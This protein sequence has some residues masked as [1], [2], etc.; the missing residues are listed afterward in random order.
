MINIAKQILLENNFCTLATLTPNGE[1]WSTPLAYF[2]FSN[3]FT[4]YWASWKGNQHSKNIRNDGRGF[5]TIFDSTPLNTDQ[6]VDGNFIDARIE[7]KI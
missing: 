1:P 6:E 7:I 2:N 5:I 4:L 3:D